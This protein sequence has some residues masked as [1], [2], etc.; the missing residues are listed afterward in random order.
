MEGQI[1]RLIDSEIEAK[2][3]GEVDRET[4]RKEFF[5][6]RWTGWWE[7]RNNR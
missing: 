3:D 1:E 5:I 7:Y 2:I 4:D 6:D